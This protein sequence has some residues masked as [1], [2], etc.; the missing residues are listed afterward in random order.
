MLKRTLLTSLL[1]SGF[2]WFVSCDSEDTESP[3]VTITQ[4]A[5]NAVVSGNV[6]IKATITDNEEVSR[7][8]FYI[9]GNPK[10]TVTTGTDSEYTYSWDA[11]AETPGS[12][13][14]IQVRAYDGSENMGA[15]N[16]AVTITGGAGEGMEHSGYIRENEIWHAAD[17]P[18]IV[19]GDVTVE[20]TL[21]LEP[22]VIVRFN[23]GTGLW[24]GYSA[25]GALVAQGSSGSLIYFTSNVNPAS[26]GDW[27]GIVF[28][29]Y[30]IDAATVLDYCVIE[31]GGGNGYGEIQCNA[32]SPSITKST[33]RRSSSYGIYAD[34][35]GFDAFSNN[36]VTE[37]A[38]YPIYIRAGQVHTLGSGNDFSGNSK[39]GVVVDYDDVTITCTWRNHGVPYVIKDDVTVEG[40]ASPI[41]TI[42]SGCILKFMAG[43]GF[44]VGYSESGALRADGV[45]FTSA[46]SPAS[47]GD[48]LGITFED[49]TMDAGSELKDCTV[50]YGGGNGYGAIYLSVS[51]PAI[52]GCE[53]ASSDSWG[54]YLYYSDLNPVD[55][56]ANNSFHD[57]RDGDVGP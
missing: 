50:E 21:T 19:V 29:D 45:T 38:D 52:T 37:N 35:E 36:E 51:S 6:E 48:W 5:N 2:I 39:Q 23:S 20:A 26:P 57:N 44:Y 7:V 30:T 22:G 16:V 9:D 54:I 34:D 10:D 32:A 31:Y 49:Y 17:N 18:H 12:G 8:E 40:N 14:T 13:H 25:P 27:L 1:V 46:A 55:L 42:A 24:I 53:I 4:P 11:S 15:D 3:E 28:D 56:L 43:A 33:I 47:R 41:L